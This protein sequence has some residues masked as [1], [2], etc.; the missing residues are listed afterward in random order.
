MA[1][2]KYYQ[3]RNNHLDQFNARYYI[4]VDED[5]SIYISDNGN[6]RVMKWSEGAKEGFVV[7]GNQ[8]EG[9]N[10]TQLAYSDG[11]IVDQMG[12][13][14]VSDKGNHRVMH[15]FKGATEGSLVVGENRSG[16]KTS[17]LTNPCDL[18]FDLHNN[19]RV[20]KFNIESNPNC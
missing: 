8:D 17:Q 14:Y 13:I 18:S 11:I 10:V 16:R 19:Y 9:D 4:Y 5:H 12:T 7:A 15:W 3:W 2:T 20:Q 1:S 6:H